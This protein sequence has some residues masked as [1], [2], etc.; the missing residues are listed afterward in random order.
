MEQVG[1]TNR[2]FIKDEPILFERAVEKALARR[3]GE[4]G[5]VGS[6]YRRRGCPTSAT[7]LFAKY[8]RIEIASFSRF[9]RSPASQAWLGTFTVCWLKLMRMSSRRSSLG[10][11]RQCSRLEWSNRC[12]T[13]AVF[14]GAL[15][16]RAFDRSPNK[17]VQTDACAG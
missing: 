6:S 11:G 12:S 10:R 4:S 7:A 8:R 17:C 5:L 13:S 9:Q 2:R 1:F 16:I 3:Y 15:G 14:V